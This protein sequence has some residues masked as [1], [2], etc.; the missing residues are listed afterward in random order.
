[1]L[2]AHISLLC[3]YIFFTNRMLLITI[4]I[5]LGSYKP[6]TIS[7]DRGELCSTIPAATDEL[8]RDP[9]MCGGDAERG[10]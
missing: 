1:M 5:V 7:A 4:P 6:S 10:M 3:L 2:P 8:M 9:A